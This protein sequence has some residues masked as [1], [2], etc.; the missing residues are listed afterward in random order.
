MQPSQCPATAPKK[1]PKHSR[2]FLK[3]CLFISASTA[4]DYR[5]RA[6]NLQPAYQEAWDRHRGDPEDMKEWLRVER[7]IAMRDAFQN[8][9]WKLL[10]NLLR[11]LVLSD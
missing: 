6:R 7:S 10:Y 2:R 11:L 5:E 1:V 9:N 3:I 4:D 8:F